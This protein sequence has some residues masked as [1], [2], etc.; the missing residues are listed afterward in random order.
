MT[1]STENVAKNVA[2]E[3]VQDYVKKSHITTEN[4]PKSEKTA[5]DVQKNC[6][7]LTEKWKNGELK[8]GWYYVETNEPFKPSKV[9]ILEYYRTS[10]ESDIDSNYIYK[11][12]APVPSYEE[13]EEKQKALKVLAEAYCKEKQENQ[14]LEKLLKKVRC[15]LLDD[16]DI[17]DRILLCETIDEVLK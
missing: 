1:N 11:I 15:Y 17:E 2:N 8:D 9:I 16:Y 3:K 7:S 6:S 13:W 14:R 10:F 12:I 5:Q 4:E